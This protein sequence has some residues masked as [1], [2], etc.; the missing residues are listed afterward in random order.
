MLKQTLCA[1][2]MSYLTREMVQSALTR[3]RT[4]EGEMRSLFDSYGLPLG[5]NI[6]RRNII[7]SHAQEN[8]FARE[9]AQSWSVKVD[10]R[11]GEADIVLPDLDREL[12]C[13]ISSGSGKYKNYSLQTDYVTLTRK[14][15]LDFLFVLADPAFEKF[16]V[17]HFEEL[18]PDDFHPP[19]PGARHKARMRKD[20][21]MDRCNVLWGSV[22][23]RNEREL[24]KIAR[25]MRELDESW[26][27]R[28]SGLRERIERATPST[29]KQLNSVLEGERLSMRRSAEKLQVRTDYWRNSTPSF[30]I[31]LAPLET[32]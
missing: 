2:E 7:M 6:G 28:Q 3:M 15:E 20:R 17:L 18:T 11:T 4:F 21:A 16:A 24:K 23:C 26:I 32:D 8:F 29:V 19:S 9:L 10:G 30:T 13:K 31:T 22:S 12:E 27:G 25:L 1:G 14:G 5:D